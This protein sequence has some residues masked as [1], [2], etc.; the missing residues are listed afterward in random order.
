MRLRGA[1]LRRRPVLAWAALS[2]LAWNALRM[3]AGLAV[4]A[5]WETLYDWFVA[6]TRAAGAL[7]AVAALVVG[8]LWSRRA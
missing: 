2:A 6:Y 8:L 5:S 4:G 7:L 1:A 3:A